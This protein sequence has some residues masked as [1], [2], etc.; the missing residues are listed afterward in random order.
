MSG[1]S[2][3]DPGV[4]A[5]LRHALATLAYRTG[6]AVR[7]TDAAYSEY[8]A[9]PE[10]NSPRTILA[11]MG[12]LLDWLLRMARDGERV[13][14]AAAPLPWEQEQAR[15]FAA[16]GALDAQ[17]ASDAPLQFDPGLLFQGGIADALTHTGQLAML[18]RLA[19][20]KMKGE[21]YSRAEIVAGR[22]GAEQV[23]PKPEYE[24]D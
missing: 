11:H 3:D 15:F 2:P 20:R 7:G 24:F 21:N 18:R 17:L 10:S 1:L 5:F 13:W 14:T 23:P 8:L 22:V 12:D 6:K 9:S 16:L 19:G 4:R